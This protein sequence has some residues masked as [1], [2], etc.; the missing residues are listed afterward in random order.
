M[1]SNEEIVDIMKITKSFKESSLLKQCV[2]ETTKSEA[3]EPKEGFLGM[4]LGT[5]TAS[6]FWNILEVKPEIHGRGV[7][8]AS[9]GVIWAAKKTIRTWKCF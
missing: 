1:I 8:R 3:K 5:L 9:E 7:V 2:C 4:L 6:L